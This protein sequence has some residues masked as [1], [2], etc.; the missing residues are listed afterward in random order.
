MKS[1]TLGMKGNIINMQKLQKLLKG[2]EDNL[3]K[4]ITPKRLAIFLTIVYVISLI[5]LLW[6]GFYNYPSADDYSIGSNCRQMWVN[7]HNIFAVLWAGVVRAVEDWLYWM[8]YFTSNFLM[9]VPP[10]VFGE[11]VYVLTVWIMLSMLSLSTW[12]LLKNIFIKVFHGDKYISH[13]IIMLMLFI[14]VQCMVGRVEAFYWYAGAANYI[15]VHSMSLFFNGLLIAAVYDKGKKRTFDLVTA[16]ILGF[17]VGGGNQMTALNTAVIMLVIIG[18][19]IVLKK[20]K[21]NKVLL[22]PICLNLFGF[23][24][25]V[26]APGNW[27]RAA[28][29]DGMNPIKAVMVSFYYCLDYCMHEWSGWPVLVL[30]IVLI[31]LFWKLVQRTDFSFGYPLVV[32]L[33]GYCLV[34]AMLT[35]PLFAVGNIESARLQALTFAMYI[36]VLTLCEGYVIGY[37]RRKLSAQVKEELREAVDV[38][39]FATGEVWCILGCI[40]FFSMASLLTVIPEP[41]YFTASSAMTDLLSGDAKAY[42]DALKERTALYHSGEKN[43]VVA[44][45]PTQPELLYFSDIKEDP[46]DWEN[47]G[48]CRFYDLESVVVDAK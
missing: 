18:F 10:N 45:L 25:N 14:T 48:L 15:L 7:S 47:N 37:V 24:L 11:R 17:L 32:V 8:G 44:P 19:G 2:L 36:L 3:T 35:P 27:V 22:I 5:P 20:W 1:I 38:S 12:Y 4:W 39:R 13:C 34:A 46:Q 9:A 21:S 40:L 42:G 33:F 16:G 29:T 41:H 43:I 6:I 28:G 30:M 26:A 23:I 31:P